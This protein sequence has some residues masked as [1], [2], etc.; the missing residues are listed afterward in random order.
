M[1]IKEELRKIREIE[2]SYPIEYFINDALKVCGYAKEDGF[3]LDDIIAELKNLN[4]NTGKLHS[5]YGKYYDENNRIRKQYI[6]IA[7][8][9][10]CIGHDI[11]MI[12]KKLSII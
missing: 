10:Q 12:D 7:G 6:S 3:I 8:Y 11:Y 1:N 9:M 5:I 4:N 2:M